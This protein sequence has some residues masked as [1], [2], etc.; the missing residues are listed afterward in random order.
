MSSKDRVFGGSPFAGPAGPGDATK[1]APNYALEMLD[2]VKIYGTTRVLDG[3]NFRVR[4]GSIHALLGANGAGK[5]TLLKIADGAASATSGQLRVKGIDHR[6]SNPLQARKSGIGMVFQERS[7]LPAL[8]VADNVFLNDE[9][10]RGWLIDLGAQTR[11]T[12]RLFGRLGENIS[13]HIRTNRMGVGDQQMVEIVKALRLATSVLILDEPTAALNAREVQRLFTVIRQIAASGV[14]VIYVSHRLAE[15]FELCDEVTVL[16]DGKVV[17]NQPMADTDMRHVIEAMTGGEL[18]EV[19][20]RR[21]LRDECDGRRPMLEVREL[22]VG[23]KLRGVSFQAKAG[24]IL[25]VAGLAGSGR[26][27]LL[28]A[29]FGAIPRQAGKIIVDGEEANPKSPAKAIER[30]IYLI[31]EDRKA[32]GLVLSHSVEANLV[33]SILRETRFGPFFDRR[34]A[35]HIA[36]E[37]IR[38]LAIKTTGPEQ[39]VDRL[40]GGNQQ[41][42]VLGKAFNA[43]GKV[44][45]LDEPTFGVDVHSSAEIG[46]RARQFS[47]EGNTVLWVTS[48][49]LELTRMADRIMILVDGTVSD[50]LPNWPHPLTEQ[51]I[52]R[53]IQPQSVAVAEHARTEVL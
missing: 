49:L 4:A 21:E 53:L 32:E 52:S 2:I 10:R 3:V 6:F 12:A 31:P 40:S 48:D 17:M 14:A 1:V 26:S 20:A 22:E 50:I 9:L 24:E 46:D 34:R 51:E 5:S 18:R 37:A 27:T 30:G 7:I 42:I 29:I 11:E 8:S 13:P 23:D 36:W 45:L 16:R 25:G 41:K 35:S 43:H 39:V 44:L 28:K 19:D 47:A 38:A 15:V 33:L